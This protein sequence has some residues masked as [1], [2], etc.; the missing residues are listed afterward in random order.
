MD[1]YLLKRME[2]DA[3]LAAEEAGGADLTELG[4]RALALEKQIKG[5]EN[6]A[7]RLKKELERMMRYSIPDAF[8]VAGVSEFGFVHE[9]GKARMSTGT[10]VVGSLTRADDKDAAIEYLEANGLKGAIKT[11][12]AMQF[13]KD[14]EEEVEKTVKLLT[15]T[16]NRHVDV[17]RGIHPQTLVAFVRE[18]LKEDPTFDYEKVGCTAITEAKFTLRR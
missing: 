6:D 16:S 11:K 2:E 12:L 9:G 1:E 10:K 8:R 4:K 3:A 17:E 5:Y 14:E 7:K 15:Q 18:K 13:D